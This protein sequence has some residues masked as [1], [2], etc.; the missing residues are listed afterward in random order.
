MTNHTDIM[1][2]AIQIFRERGLQYGSVESTF[3]RTAKLASILLDAEI[4]PYQVTMVHV[5]TKLA[6]LQD[7][8][9]LDDNYVD[10]MN[11]LAFSAQFAPVHETPNITEIPDGAAGGASPEIKDAVDLVDDGVKKIA[12]MFSAKAASQNPEPEKASE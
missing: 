6:R 10:A 4:T 12:K 8:R 2:Q 3:D 5:A 11:Y 9:A 1:N 7:S